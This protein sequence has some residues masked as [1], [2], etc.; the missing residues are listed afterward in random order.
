MVQPQLGIPDFV[1]SSREK[2]KIGGNVGEWREVEVG[3]TGVGMQNENKTK[4]M[5]TKK[6]KKRKENCF[7][8]NIKEV[9]SSEL[10]TLM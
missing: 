5:Q 10:K 2:F 1:Y 8:K 9:N 6:E 3:G 4:S 7:G